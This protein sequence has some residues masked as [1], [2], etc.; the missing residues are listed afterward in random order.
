MIMKLN[1]KAKE[2]AHAAK[3]LAE[4]NALRQKYGRVALTEAD[5]ADDVKPAEA[6]EEVKETDAPA[7]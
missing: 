6:E 5:L 3:V 1:K 7:E 4:F 2:E